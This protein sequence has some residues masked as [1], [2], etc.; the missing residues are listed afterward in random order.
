MGIEDYFYL[1][2]CFSDTRRAYHNPLLV[3]LIIAIVNDVEEAK[4]VNT[5]A[6]GNDTEPVTEEV[7]L[8]E[9]LGTIDFKRNQ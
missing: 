2:T 3:I 1:H 5:L 6:S 8:E 9:L 4:F 7:L